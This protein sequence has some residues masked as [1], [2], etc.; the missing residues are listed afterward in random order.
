MNKLSFVRWAGFLAAL[1]GAVTAGAAGDYVTAGSIIGAA[2]SSAQILPGVK[3][4]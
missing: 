1:A 3:T 4:Q 2:V